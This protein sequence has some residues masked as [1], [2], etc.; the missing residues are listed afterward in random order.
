[1]P[2]QA[3][4]DIPLRLASELGLQ[5]NSLQFSGPPG[6]RVVFGASKALKHDLAGDYS[7]ITF[8]AQNELLDHWIAAIILDLDRDWTWDG[9]QDPSFT[10]FRDDNPNPAGYLNV[11][12]TVGTSAVIQPVER[13][14]TRLGFFDAVDPNPPASHAG[15]F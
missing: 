1:M 11:R 4:N 7:A 13:G 2:F 8:A 3:A 6:E 15:Q 14:L 5:V 10:V 12:Q 9:L